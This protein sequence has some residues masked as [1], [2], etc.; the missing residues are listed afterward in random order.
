[1]IRLYHVL[2]GFIFIPI[3]V[4]VAASYFS[5]NSTNEDS[6]PSSVKTPIP[7]VVSAKSNQDNIWKNLIVDTPLPSGWKINPCQDKNSMLCVSANA[8]LVGTVELSILPLETQPNFQKMLFNAGIPIDKNINYRSPKYITQI[9]TALN[10]W[11]KNHY[12]LLAKN[13]KYVY[14]DKL[15]TA[16]TADGILFSAYP[17][18]KAQVGKLQGIRYGFAGL[19]QKGGVHEQHTGY[20]AFDGKSLYLINTAF[21][22]TSSIAKFEKLENLSIFQPYLNALVE[23]LKLPN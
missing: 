13:N 10:D 19:K 14:E 7:T 17:P 11:V 12:D 20:V 1:M 4:T 22:P 6:Q 2:L 18:Q 5:A 16:K 21:D 9:T 3:G 23:N 15:K 8:K